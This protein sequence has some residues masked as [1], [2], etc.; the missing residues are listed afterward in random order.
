LA[1][2]RLCD[3]TLCFLAILAVYPQFQIN[4]QICWPS[5]QHVL[6]TV[7][8]TFSRR[9]KWPFPNSSPLCQTESLFAQQWPTLTSPPRIRGFVP[10]PGRV[11]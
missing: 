10:G 7:R 5:P 9:Y 8:G 11:Q 4:L 3:P 1:V 6:S 2:W